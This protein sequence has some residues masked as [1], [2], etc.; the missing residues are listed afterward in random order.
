ML[1]LSENSILKDKIKCQPKYVIYQAIFD[2]VRRSAGLARRDKSDPK[3][4]FNNRNEVVYKG[5]FADNEPPQNFINTTLKILQKNINKS[6][7]VS[8][9]FHQ[10][11]NVSFEQVDL[12][13]GIVNAARKNFEEAYP[14]SEFHVIFWDIHN[15]KKSHYLVDSLTKTG[16]VVHLISDIF[17]EKSIE[18]IQEKYKIKYDGHPN[19]L[20]YRNISEYVVNSIVE[21]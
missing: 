11:S 6:M 10:R 12:M 20:A 4:I 8:K 1:A 7:I 16:L 5:S 15:I 9:I 19:Q 18:K 17:Q 14:E 3:Y 2:H 13:I 21:E